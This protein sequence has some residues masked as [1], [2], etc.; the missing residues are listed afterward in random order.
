MVCSIQQQKQIVEAAKVEYKRLADLQKQGFEDDLE[1]NILDIQEAMDNMRAII[2]RKPENIVQTNYETVDSMFINELNN[3]NPKDNKVNIKVLNGVRTAS[4]KLIYTVKYPNN[5]KEYKLPAS[6]ITADQVSANEGQWNTVSNV[7]LTEE[8]Y[9]R[10]QRVSETRQMAVKLEDERASKLNDTSAWKRYTDSAPK[11]V[12]GHDRYSGAL[13]NIIEKLVD[14]K[15]VTDVAGLMLS[16]VHEDNIVVGDYNLDTHTLQIAKEPIKEEIDNVAET[17]LIQLY[18][19]KNPNN[20]N[21]DKLVEFVGA[22]K[23]KAIERILDAVEKVRGSHVLTH[24]L[25]HAGSARFIKDNPKHPAVKRV[26]E[27]YNEAMSKK[28]DIQSLV[29]QGDIITTRWQ[30]NKDEFVAEALSNPG[31]MNALSQIE[32]NNKGKLSNMLRDLMNSLL[33]MLGLSKK[34]K[35]NLLEFTM[36]GFAAIIEAQSD[37]S[38]LMTDKVRDLVKKYRESDKISKGSD[39]NT[40]IGD[41]KAD[42]FLGQEEIDLGQ[43]LA[44]DFAAYYE[45]DVQEGRP[46]QTQEFADLQ[47][48]V[49]DTY[50]QTMQDLGTGNVKLRMFENMVDNTAGQIDLRT[51]EMHIRWNKM[52]RL[53]RVSEVFLHEINHLMSSHVFKDNIKLRRLMEDLRDSAIASG[54]TYELFLEGIQNPTVEEVEIAKMKFEY[55]FD[56]TA[57]AEEFYA[58]ATTNENVY[59]AIKDIKISTPL[60]KALEMDPTKKSPMKKVLNKLI[61]VV[62][63]VWRLLSGRGET[64]GKMI[65]DMVHTIAKLDAE[66]AQKDWKAEEDPEGISGYAKGKINQL[67]EAL[68][69]VTD[70]VEEWNEKLSAKANAKWLA[71]HIKKVP[72]LNDLVE[73]GIS[74]Y[75][76]RMVTQDTTSND[77][78]DMYMIFRHAK[79]VIE[80]HTSDIRNGVQAVATEMYEGVDEDTKNAVTRVILEGDLA[81]FTAEELKEYMLDGSKVDAKIESLQKQILASPEGMTDVKQIIKLDKANKAMMEQIDGLAEYLVSGKTTTYNQQINANNIISELYVDK[82]KHKNANKELVKLVDKLV[83]LKVLKNSDATQLELISKLDNDLLNKTIT[84]YRGYIDNMRLDATLGAYDPVPKGY[85]R[86]EDGLIK[87]E[88]IPEEEVKAQQSVLMDLVEEKPYVIVENK[89]YY[90]MTGRTK[91]VGFN[92]GAIGLISHTTEGIPV[93]AL[94]RKNNE[95]AG[96]VELMDGELKRKT[97]NIINAIS[98]SDEN[99][100]GKFKMG[101]GQTLVPVYDHQNKI[102]DYRIQLNKLEKEIH[103]PDRKTGL[104]DVLS[105]TFSRSIKTTLTA[106]ENKR[107]VDTIIENSAQGVLEKPDEYVLVEEYTEEDKMNGVKR[108]KRHDR[109]EYLP[110]HT[111]DYIFQKTKNKGILI[112]KDFVELMTGEKDVTI[113]NFAK[114]GIDIKKYPVAKARLMALE[115]YLAEILGYVKNAMVVL[116]ADVLLGNQTSNVIVAITHGINPIKYTKKFKERWQQ[117]NDYNEK[118]QQLAELEVKKMAGENVNRKMNQL[119]K[120]LEGNVWDELVKDG[121]YTALV[122]DINIDGQG[123]GQLMTMAKDYLDKK[124]WLGV[125]DTVKNGLYINRTSAFYNTMLKT[126]HYGDAITRQ[127]IKEELEAK[128]IKRDGEVTASV[129]REI[130]NYLDQLLVNYGYTMNRWWKYAERVGGLFF[131]KYY[132]S[133]AKAIMSMTKK[134][135]TRT[136]LMQGAQQLTGI[137]FQDPIDTYLRTGIDGVSYR[138]LLDDAPE[139]ILQPNIFDLIPDLGSIFRIN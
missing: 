130:L 32:T 37:K 86:A 110:D 106:T 15:I 117:L 21:M 60:I 108:E 75:L 3:N 85:I 53:S 84:M 87:Y 112:H 133:Q 66:K 94:I 82:K 30:A 78:A 81:Q 65:A 116:N 7:Y 134:N 118:S 72:L 23:A 107:V 14:P 8:A 50:Q 76:W 12:Y 36:D 26:E 18:I 47:N 129:E 92:E 43:V 34:V 123:E 79:Q 97:K 93:S 6:R 89:K 44:D 45:A 77:V 111:K 22:N 96:K 48:T 51:K 91:S 46:I 90:L 59:N 35:N 5:E 80:K 139:Q 102:V 120:Q 101:K 33:D 52:S 49:V 10:A 38:T 55:T 13:G 135:P 121:Q 104:E 56:K 2:Y 58:Y 54:V 41:T 31:L 73:T 27:L 74:Q 124:N 100:A 95:L 64:G 68:K 71:N 131:M 19:N 69:P 105:H 98:S 29:N 128:A 63:Y 11:G 115:S 99:V 119:K 88:L 113:G 132:L 9:N 17:A 70:K 25:I 40:G 1:N 39:E 122:E 126:V 138:W 109:W 28:D 103:L 16:K 20:T 62:N 57:N 137:D 24:E 125:V 114:F 83:S 61:K 67:D 4:G 136:A 127:I 42:V